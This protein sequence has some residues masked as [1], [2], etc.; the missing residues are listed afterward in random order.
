MQQFTIDLDDNQ[1]RILC[2][3]GAWRGETAQSNP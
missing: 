3:L 1:L 2:E